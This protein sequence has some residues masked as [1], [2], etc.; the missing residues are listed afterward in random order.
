MTILV[1]LIGLSA[2]IV[3]HELGHMLTA[4]AMGVKVTEFG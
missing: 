1:A 3:I 2:L 4:K